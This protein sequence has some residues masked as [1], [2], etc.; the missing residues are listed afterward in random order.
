LLNNET[1]ILNILRELPSPALEEVKIF[2]D[3]LVGRHEHNS[4]EKANLITSLK[5]KAT[6]TMTNDEIL[7]LIRGEE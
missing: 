5:G 6:N 1:E 7:N 3:F 2:L 4:P